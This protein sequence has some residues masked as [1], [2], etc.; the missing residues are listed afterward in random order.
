MGA[1]KEKFGFVNKIFVE[2]IKSLPGIMPCVHIF[3]EKFD[4]IGVSV[5]C[6]IIKM[7]IKSSISKMLKSEKN[8]LYQRC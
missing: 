5:L 8:Q 7:W 2:W 3:N 6:D 4:T 1:F